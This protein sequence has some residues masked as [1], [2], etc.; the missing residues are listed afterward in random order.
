MAQLVHE[1]SSPLSLLWMK[2]ADNPT[3]PASTAAVERLR[4][5]LAYG[6]T[7]LIVAPL[8]LE[9]GPVA[10]WLH[11]AMELLT[12]SGA[13]D[14]PKLGDTEDCHA[15][16]PADDRWAEALLC[17]VV[18]AAT[19]GA[20][21]AAL[22]VMLRQSGDKTRLTVTSAAAISRDPGCW[23]IGWRSMRRRVWPGCA[24]GD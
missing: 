15:L 9:A 4:Q 20:P 13:L 1:L 18:E 8:P 3:D 5:L 22:G 12:L 21:G 16:L 23:R 2:F 10:P 6:A 24:A 17:G 7:A 11:R 14:G 19:Y